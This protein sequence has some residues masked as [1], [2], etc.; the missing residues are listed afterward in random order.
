METLNITFYDNK[1][2]KV[3]AKL[4]TFISAEMIVEMTQI[5]RKYAK[6]HDDFIALIN[7]E[8]FDIT[9]LNDNDYLRVKKHFEKTLSRLNDTQSH[10]ILNVF[11]QVY[12]LYQ[13][14]MNR[15]IVPIITDTKSIKNKDILDMLENTNATLWGK[16]DINSFRQIC[17]KVRQ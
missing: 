17:E 16:Q 12:A 15:E 7:S 6:I 13:D 14:D 2:Q 8:E 3:E 10:N 9:S 5:L 4:K 11:N 1:E